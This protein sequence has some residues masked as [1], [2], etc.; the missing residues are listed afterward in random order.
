LLRF[1]VKL[2]RPRRP[3][4][5]LRALAAAVTLLLLAGQALATLHQLIVP[6]QLCAEHGHLVHAKRSSARTPSSEQPLGEL[7]QPGA[8]DSDE[9]AHCSLA[10]RR[11]ERRCVLGNATASVSAPSECSASTPALERAAPSAG[12]PLLLLAPKQSPPS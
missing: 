5:A 4:Q 1:S 7:A 3:L 11:E 8:R 12:P 2:I 9:H 6:H 10:V